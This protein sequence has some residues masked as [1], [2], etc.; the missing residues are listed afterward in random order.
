MRIIIDKQPQAELDADLALFE[1]MFA[2]K[3]RFF[4]EL[5]ENC[6]ANNS[7]DPSELRQETVYVIAHF[8]YLLK[9]FKIDSPEKLQKFALTHNQNILD[10]LED[11]EERIKLGLQP[12]RLQGAL[13]NTDDNL[14]RLR[15]NCGAN[16]IKF[17]QSDLGRFLIEYMSAETCRSA[18]RVLSDAGYLSRSRSPFGSVIISSNGDLEEIFA[19]YIHSFRLALN[20]HPGIAHRSLRV[21]E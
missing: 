5:V 8:F 15:L 21:V 18:V 16:G 13:F 20:K 3:A 9:V 11:P 2:S 6:G 17:S 19:G 1:E 12:Q 7:V 10:L 4:D 14:D